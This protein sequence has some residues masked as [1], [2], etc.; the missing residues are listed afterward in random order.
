MNSFFMFDLYSV[1]Y[2]S[3]LARPQYQLQ[4]KI[5]FFKPFVDMNLYHSLSRLRNTGR[6]WYNVRKAAIISGCR[7]GLQPE[8]EVGMNPHFV[9]CGRIIEREKGL[10][11]GPFHTFPATVVI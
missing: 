2:I 3:V 6:K 5:S 11:A 10:S 4:Q 7:Q 8:T 1:Y 9:A